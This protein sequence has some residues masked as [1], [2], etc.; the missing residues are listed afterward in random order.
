MTQR[1]ATLAARLRALHRPGQPLVLPNAWDAA[2][3][4]RFAG[5]GVPALATSSA[6]VAQ[7]LGFADHEAIP[8]AEMF[9]AVARIAA[10]V[11]LPVTADLEA[12]YRLP[13]DVLVRELL[14]AGGV[15]LNLEDTDHAARGRLVDPDRQAERLGAVKRAARATGVDVVL[16]ARVDVFLG[17]VPDAERVAEGIRRGRL[18]AEAGA[19][20]VYPILASEE[21][22]IAALVSGI[23]APLNVMARPQ[24]LPLARLSALG[25]A[26]VT[27]GS[28]LMRAALDAAERVLG[29]FLGSAGAT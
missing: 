7:A 13:A 14:A 19:D 8:P 10:A 20:C 4:R 23:P 1:L 27:F 16:N 26:R 22:D 25:V 5:L 11:E 29:E 21:A 15:G 6:A 9:G 18:Y 17:K 24:G 12:G 2:S 28:G 3:A